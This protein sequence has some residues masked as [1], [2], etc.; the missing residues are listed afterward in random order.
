VK[1][2]QRL[3]LDMGAFALITLQ[4]NPAFSGLP[5]HEIT[6][7]VLVVPL[8]IHVVLNWS[9]VMTAIDR[10]L[11]NVRPSMRYN[12][13]VD[14]G[15][16]LSMMT[17]GISGLLIMPGLAG[18]ARIPVSPIWHSVHLAGSNLTIAFFTAHFALHGRWMLNV[19]RRMFNGKVGSP[20]GTGVRPGTAHTSTAA[21]AR[22]AAP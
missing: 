21:A 6:G 16:F 15:L 22:T 14:M 7:L 8:A 2:N 3:M 19:S 9:W 20:R 5:I 4:T 17:V 13:I 11:G 18:L 1:A 12:L 10:F